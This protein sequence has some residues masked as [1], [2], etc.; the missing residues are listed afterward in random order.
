MK[1][2]CVRPTQG[3]LLMAVERLNRVDAA[4]RQNYE[5][6]SRSSVIGQN[7]SSLSLV[8]SSQSY[9]S[10]PSQ[11]PVNIACCAGD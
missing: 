11:R 3:K 2:P 4:H 6:C 8:R 10:V 5:V 1:R 7:A 9:P